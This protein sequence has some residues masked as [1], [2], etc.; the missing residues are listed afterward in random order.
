[1]QY[2][3]LSFLCSTYY[4]VN[5]ITVVEQE[6]FLP[7]MVRAITAIRKHADCPDVQEMALGLLGH[8]AKARNNV[9]IL[10]HEDVLTTVQTLTTRALDTRCPQMCMRALHFLCNLSCH[11]NGVEGSDCAK[12]PASALGRFAPSAIAL[13]RLH[14]MDRSCIRLSGLRFIRRLCECKVLSPHL[15]LDAVNVAL[16]VML[17]HTTEHDVQEHA[18]CILIQCALPLVHNSGPLAQVVGAVCDAM[19]LHAARPI[20]QT[21][22]LFFLRALAHARG[23]G[24]CYKH[25]RMAVGIVEATM[26]AHKDVRVIQFLGLSLL[27]TLALKRDEDEVS[28]DSAEAAAALGRVTEYAISGALLHYLEHRQE[29]DACYR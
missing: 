17:P 5:D 3:T 10:T 25:L 13:T 7:L 2:T 19:Y 22:G 20:L 24:S 15:L 26:V 23:A 12:S 21:S 11:E 14:V 9:P 27:S 8:M 1:V 4:F 28:E 29:L 18:L 16:D 6:V